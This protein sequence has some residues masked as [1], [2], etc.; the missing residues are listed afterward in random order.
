MKNK[1]VIDGEYFNTVITIDYENGELF[2][3]EGS[4]GCT[5]KPKSKKELLEDICNYVLDCWDPQEDFNVE[6]KER[7]E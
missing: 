7:K 5:Y 2:I 4:S 1:S 6:I 3:A